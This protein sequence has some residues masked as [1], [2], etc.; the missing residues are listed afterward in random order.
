MPSSAMPRSAVLQVS[1]D[2]TGMARVSVPVGTISAR[3]QRR[4]DGIARQQADQVTQRRKRSIEHVGGAAAVDHAAVA[5]QVDLEI[6]S[7]FCHC[8]ARDPIC[9]AARSAAHHAWR[10]RRRCR[11]R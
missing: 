9:V 5:Q 6:V 3:R 2:F 1:L 8:A 4:M 7:A 10:L 11:R